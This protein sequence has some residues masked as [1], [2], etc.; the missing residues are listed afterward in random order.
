YVSV[1][2]KH[3][4]QAQSEGSLTTIQERHSHD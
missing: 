4:K 1:C 2:R 3:Y